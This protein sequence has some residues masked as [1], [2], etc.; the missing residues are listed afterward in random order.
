MKLNLLLSAAILAGSAMMS[1]AQTHKEGV[2]YYRADQFKNAKELL[3]RN[4]NNQGTDKSISDYYLGL[5]ALQE[6]NQKE[7]ADYFNKGVTDNPEY[8]YNYIG[9]GQLE[10]MNKNSSAAKSNFDKAKKL[11]GKDPAVLIAI[12]RAYYEVDPVAYAKDINKLETDA[13]KLTPPTN[14]NGENIDYYLF[15]GD[16]FNDEKEFGKAGNNYEMATT[17]NP[18]ATEAYVK[19]ANLF[20]QVNPQYA[21]NMLQKLLQVNPTSALGQRELANAYYNAKLYKEAATQYDKYVKNPNH[22]K[23]DEDRLAFLLFV[24][25]EYQQGYDFATGL[26]KENPNNFT[27]QRFQFMNAAQLPALESSLLPMAEA[28]VAAHNSNPDN[29]FAQIDYSLIS[30][31]LLKGGKPEEAQ[32]L[33]EEAIAKEPENPE[34]YRMLSDVYVKEKNYAKTADAYSQYIAKKNEPGYNDLVQQARY[35]YFAGASNLIDN[36]DLAAQYLTQATQIADKALQIS[37]DYP[38][39]YIIKGQTAIA[40][41]ASDEDRLTAAVPFY[42]QAVTIIEG[43]PNPQRY[44]SDLRDMYTYLGNYYLRQMKDTPT[45]VQYFEKYLELAPNDQQTRDYVNSLKK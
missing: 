27:A 33:I 34:Y 11:A 22:F 13:F 7:A 20:T 31:E 35:S 8:P 29:A 43:N 9:L 25:G 28:L 30:D 17:Y 18:K 19:Y 23:Q 4:Y 3:Q 1:M 16:K 41:A 26:L 14:K 24:D 44:A 40:T 5:I 39:P 6:K 12:A 32:V 45:A 21:I 37:A 15:L 36:P 38:T 10:L 2:E 42:T